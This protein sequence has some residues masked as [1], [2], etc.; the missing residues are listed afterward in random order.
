MGWLGAAGRGGRVGDVDAGA[1]AL[2]ALGLEPV[3]GAEELTVVS[4]RSRRRG[5]SRR[6]TVCPLMALDCRA[7]STRRGTATW[8]MG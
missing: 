4:T 5:C 8:V 3:H 6:V 2:G 1:A 7:S